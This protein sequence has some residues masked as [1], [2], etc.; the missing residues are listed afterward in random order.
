MT[1]FGAEIVS[2]NFITTFKVKG[3]IYHKAGSLLPFQDGD[4]KFLQM[5]F[6]GDVNDELKA[7]CGISTGVRRSIVSQLQNL[8]HERNNL[9]RLFK[10]AIDLMPS[11]TH[12]IVIRADKTPTGEHVRRFNVPTI[13]DVAILMVGDQFQRRDIVLHRRNETLT[14]VFETHRCY[15][16]LQYPLIF[17]DGSDGYH[18]NVKMINAETGEETR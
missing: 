17:W 15:D 2:S 5:Y 1:Y 3:Q 4:H 11:D 18:F 13:D 6:I 7:R 10:T 16:A 9:V 14:K 12:K 8:L